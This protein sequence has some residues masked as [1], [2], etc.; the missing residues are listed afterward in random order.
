MKFIKRKPFKSW[1]QKKYDKLNVAFLVNIVWRRQYIFLII[2]YV[3]Y[4]KQSNWMLVKTGGWRWKWKVL[5]VILLLTSTIKFT[6]AV[7]CR[8]TPK[9]SICRFMAFLKE[10]P[11][12]KEKKDRSNY[13]NPLF[14][15]NNCLSL[16]N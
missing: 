13:W 3:S 9:R 16:L 8:N 5:M 14:V 12:R 6:L 4:H 10:S 2:L 1:N 11:W 15:T 7:V